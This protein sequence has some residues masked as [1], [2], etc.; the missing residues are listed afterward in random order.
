M[1]VAV[2]M[3][4]PETGSE[5]IPGEKMDSRTHEECVELF[6][7]QLVHPVAAHAGVVDGEGLGEEQGGVRSYLRV[8]RLHTHTHTSL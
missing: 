1:A 5:V 7:H 3:D 6:L 8:H 2:L 4:G